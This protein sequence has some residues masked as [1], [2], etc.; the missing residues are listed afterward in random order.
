MS[1]ALIDVRVVAD[2]AQLGDAKRAVIGLVYAE[3][4]E[5]CTSHESWRIAGVPDELAQAHVDSFG[6]DIAT[7]ASRLG[8]K[9]E[10][11]CVCLLPPVADG[12]QLALVGVGAD[13]D[14]E[15]VRMAYGSAARALFGVEA[16]S[17]GA[18]TIVVYPDAD[19]VRPCVEGVLLGCYRYQDLKSEAVSS[20][21]KSLAVVSAGAE[22]EV[23]AARITAKAVYLAR[24]WVNLTP[25]QLYPQ[26]FAEDAARLA[27]EAGIECTVL[28]EKELA[29]GGYGGILAVGSGSAK[30]PRL[31]RLDYHPDGATAH[32]VFVGKGITFDSGGLDLKP[33]DGMYTMKCDMA[34]AAS[35]LAATVAIAELGLNVWV[36]AYASM[37]ENMPSGS[38]YHPSDVL[39]MYGGKTV[40]NYNTDAEGRLVMADALARGCEDEPTLLI[41]V[42]TLT[43]ACMVALGDRCAGVIARD[44]H[45]A[46]RVL[47][48]AEATGEEFWQLPLQGY[49]QKRL[50][51]KIADIR[52]G[53]GRLG[54]ATTAAA[55]LSNFVADGVDWA[56]L[57]IAGP[58]FNEEEPRGY[59]CHGGTGASVRTLIQIAADLAG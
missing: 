15:T 10:A 49:A 54:G 45:N 59:I 50:A 35:V 51:S 13:D 55:F 11:G 48:A 16:E 53:G 20:A 34:G 31:A 6:H 9:A 56:H 26:T 14:A 17:D 2:C 18:D 25:N 12:T 30:P 46:D 52:S 39:T 3:D 40:E 23:A 32:L 22:D 7:L 44:Q 28:D 24:D 38:S 5:S 33:A 58:A 8:M 37:A 36:T 21:V 43:G 29:A 27:S 4:K 19:T 47:A 42:A 57:D 41:D 1:T